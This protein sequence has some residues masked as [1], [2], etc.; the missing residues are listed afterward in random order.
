MVIYS[1][2]HD[3]FG[4]GDPDSTGDKIYNGAEDNAAGCAQVLAIARAIRG[5]ARAA[6]PLGAHAVRGR[7]GAGV[8]RQQVL[9][10]ASDVRARQDRRQHQL[11][12]RQLPRPHARPHAA[13]RRQVIAR[14]ASR[15]RWSRSRAACWCPTSSRIRAISTARTS[16]HFA[17][18]GVPALYFDEGTDYIGKPAG[19]GR[20]QNEEWD[21][22]VYHQPSDEIDDTWVFDGMIEDALDR[23]LCRLAG[24]AGR[25]HADV[26]SRATSSRRRARRRWRRRS[27]HRLRTG[28]LTEC[29]CGRLPATGAGSPNRHHIA[30]AGSAVSPERGAGHQRHARSPSP[31]F[32]ALPTHPRCP[33]MLAAARGRS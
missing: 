33:R 5:A 13:R 21:E 9:L 7:R 1:A 20:Q 6:A 30:A 23:L 17:K 32:T 11:R 22:H 18:I 3:H 28:G 29:C 26:E 31:H 4:I 14:R 8:V 25:C 15:R 16:S 24:R 12:R 19:W 27:S 2:H 10:A